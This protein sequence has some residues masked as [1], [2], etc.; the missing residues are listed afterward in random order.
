MEKSEQRLSGKVNERFAIYEELVERGS[1][2][3]SDLLTN[4]RK[5][6][7]EMKRTESAYGG[8][9][10]NI[11]EF[12]DEY[13]HSWGDD[14]EITSKEPAYEN[15]KAFKS[16]LKNIPDRL[17]SAIESIETITRQNNELMDQGDIIRLKSDEL[18]SARIK[19]IEARRSFNKG[20]PTTKEK[21]VMQKAKYTSSLSEYQRL[22]DVFFRH[23]DKFGEAIESAY[24]SILFLTDKMEGRKRIYFGPGSKE[25][26]HA[27]NLKEQDETTKDLTKKVKAVQKEIQKFIKTHES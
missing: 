9:L 4:F 11:Y 6:L 23:S 21:L 16:E 5:D 1:D 20:Y 13:L 8:E 10:S 25:Y 3:D 24:D 17:S 19:L 27:M 26:D 14:R 7:A 18:K 15:Y 12:M 22:T 2:K